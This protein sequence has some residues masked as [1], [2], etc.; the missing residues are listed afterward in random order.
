M[1]RQRLSRGKMNQE[2]GDCRVR[3]AVQAGDWSPVVRS[4]VGTRRV[5]RRSGFA[6]HAVADA[7][8]PRRRSEAHRSG[9]GVAV[10]TEY[11]FVRK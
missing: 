7:L 11:G 5:R 9:E 10:R 2:P 6:L 8:K 3:L 4:S 1:G